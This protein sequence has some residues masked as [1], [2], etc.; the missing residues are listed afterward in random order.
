M[1]NSAYVAIALSVLMHVAW[2]LLAR[3]VDS[4]CNYFWWGLLAHL[5]MLGP[6]ALWR[7]FQDAHWNSHF[8]VVMLITA[9]ANSFYFLALRKAYHYAPVAIVY[10]IARSSPIL[11]ALWAW[12]FFDQ[13]I[14]VY[15]ILGITI[16]AIGLW[17]LADSSMKGDTAHAIPWAMVAAL[18]TSIYSLSDKFAV[19]YLPTFGAQL[20]FITVGYA[21]SFVIISLI[22]YRETHRIVPQCRPKLIYLLPG[23]LF[24]GT[25]YAL[26]VRAM[27]EL[28]AS[29]V[30]TYTNSGIVLATI[31]SIWIFNEREEKVRRLM[32]SVVICMGLILLGF[33]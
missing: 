31:F 22:Q 4:R 30:V 6:W 9:V 32:A 7:L 25:A 26:V 8:I 17:I 15:G 18:A 28:P 20:G 14:N 1:L 23:G 16:N 33:E 2:N 13:A 24:I 5:L 21:T 11:I 27:L 29:Y 3:H 12:L 10:P 19:S